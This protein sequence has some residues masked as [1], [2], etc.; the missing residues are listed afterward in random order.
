[1]C[2]CAQEDLWQA[3]IRLKSQNNKQTNLYV[4]EMADTYFQKAKGTILALK[5]TKHDRKLKYIVSL[6]LRMNKVVEQLNCNPYLKWISRGV[7]KCML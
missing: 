7:M 5:Y 3:V 1:M 4:S 6:R 2:F